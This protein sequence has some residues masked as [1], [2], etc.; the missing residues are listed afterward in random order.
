MFNEKDHFKEEGIEDGRVVGPTFQGANLVAEYYKYKYNAKITLK[1]FED[2]PKTQYPQVDYL[3]KI[4]TERL[5]ENSNVQELFQFYLE[6]N[7]FNIHSEAVIYLRRGKQQALVFADSSGSKNDIV[8]SK[9]YAYMLAKEF[10]IPC[11]LIEEPRQVDWY[12]CHTDSLVWGRI[13]SAN[14][15]GKYLLPDLLDFL[16]KNSTEMDGI[17]IVKKLPDELLMTSQ[18]SAFKNKYKTA[19]NKIVHKTENLEK[20]MERYPRPRFSYLRVKGIKFEN[21][22]RIQFYANELQEELQDLWT[23][24][25][26]A[27]YYKKAKDYFKKPSDLTFHQFVEDFEADVRVGLKMKP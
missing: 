5:E 26:K 9:K 1:S 6:K 19:E 20:F 25:V 11:Y 3:R 2:L 22:M 24:K 21:I 10:R 12:S 8:G 18:L 27:A 17:F 14:K 16:E 23:E 13:V 15:D 4:I 7:K